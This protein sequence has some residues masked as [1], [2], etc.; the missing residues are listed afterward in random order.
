MRTKKIKNASVVEETTRPFLRWAGGKSWLIKHLAS[1]KNGTYNNYHEAFLGG[2]ASFFF[3]EPKNQSYLS[4]LNGELIETYQ[5]VR[6]NVDLVIE[7]LK[8]FSNTED[9]YYRIRSTFFENAIER[10]AKFIYLNHTSYNGIYRVNLKGVYNVPYGFRSKDFLDQE[11]LIRA[12][13]KLR[14]TTIE[15]QDF[16]SIIDNINAGDLVFLDPPYTTSHNENGFIKYNEKIFSLDD[17]QRLSN[18]ISEIKEKDAYYILTN[19][20]HVKIDEIFEK[21][22]KKLKLSRASLIGGLQAGRGQTYEYVFT[23]TDL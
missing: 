18:M 1:I 22:D 23:N 17:Q 2:G 7:K 6:D 5:A 20:A 14:N 12:S 19:A 3:L 15:K 9:E 4:D 16:Y 10:A 8:D 11:T 13:A 21:G